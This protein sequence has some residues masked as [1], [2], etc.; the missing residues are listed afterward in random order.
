MDNFLFDYEHISF[1]SVRLIRKTQTS[2]Q[3]EYL[4]WVNAIIQ[5]RANQHVFALYISVS[6]FI[7]TPPFMWP[8][9]LITQILSEF[10][11]P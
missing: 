5:A 3:T 1:T 8:V 6:R 4:N 9:I 7:Q 2:K 11:H 10:H